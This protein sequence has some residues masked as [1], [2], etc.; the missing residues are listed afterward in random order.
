LGRLRAR[1]PEKILL[2][3]DTHHRAVSEPEAMQA[4]E[5]KHYDGVLAFGEVLR[6]IYRERGWASRCW[7][8]HEAADTRVFQPLETGRDKEYDLVWIGNW[9]DEERTEELR[10]FLIEP[11]REL[12]LKAVAHGVRYP[13][14]GIHQLAEAGIEYRGWLPNYHAPR[15]FARARL[16]V[17]IPRRPYTQALPGIPTIRP[18][19]ALACGIPLI[20]APW[21]DAE[22]LFHGSKDYL[23]AGNGREM[24]GAMQQIL[25]HPQTGRELS[26]HGLETIQKHHTCRHRVSE[27]MEVI[28]EIRADRARAESDTTKKVRA[29]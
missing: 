5:L 14:E 3:H 11:V 1:H 7:S 12:G 15:V 23:T 22:N 29:A 4:Y 13:A 17:H 16:T 24:A 18:F 26:R 9:G 28:E 21:D 20:C 10:E 6:E 27:L 25:D 19:E 8:W 2:F